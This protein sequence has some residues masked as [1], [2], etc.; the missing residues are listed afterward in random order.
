MKM[1][2]RMLTGMSGLHSVSCK[3]KGQVYITQF[4]VVLIWDVASEIFN[5]NQ[6]ST[7]QIKDFSTKICT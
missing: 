7:G 6:E 5:S 4:T 1:H 3:R 2:I